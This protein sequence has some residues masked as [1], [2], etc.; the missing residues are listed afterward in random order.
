MLT[1]A[2]TSPVA[3]RWPRI[4]PCG[5]SSWWSARYGSR[6]SP[7]CRVDPGELQTPVG[8]VEPE[9]HRASVRLHRRLRD[10]GVLAR[11]RVWEGMW[12]AFESVPGLPEA[13]QNL[14][15]VFTFLARHH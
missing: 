11:L 13:E 12:H 5:R 14:A 8:A 9:D 7:P 3:P 6:P 1:A 10:S 4:F 15:E 2:L